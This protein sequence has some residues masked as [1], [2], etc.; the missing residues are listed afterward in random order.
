MPLTIKFSEKELL[1]GIKQ[2]NRYS[3][4]FLFKQYYCNLCSY[5]LIF[6]K[7]KDLAEEIVQETLIK[8]WENR[9]KIEINFSLKA[10]IYKSV[11]NH[12]LIY[13]KKNDMLRRKYNKMAEELS[14]HYELA[15]KNLDPRIN[16][17]MADYENEIKLDKIMQELPDQCREIFY[18]SRFEKKT[19]QQIANSLNLS[20][21]TVKTQ[22]KRA[23]YKL[24]T[25]Y[26]QECLVE[27]EINY[28]S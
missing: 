18:K 21:N 7:S 11:Y 20:V 14:Y 5:A 13:I 1:E 24:K 3:F 28:L 12:C 17:F 8:F 6:V 15:N 9:S 4:E 27:S 22:M 23:I 26:A 2:N 25:L 16:E 10:Y 19:Y